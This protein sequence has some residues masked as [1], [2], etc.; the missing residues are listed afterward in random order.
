MFVAPQAQNAASAEFLNRRITETPLV[1]F[2]TSLACPPERKALCTQD[3]G[4][5]RETP[6]CRVNL[7]ANE[8]RQHLTKPFASINGRYLS[9]QYPAGSRS[10]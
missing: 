10:S 7:H 3:S 5:V 4:G 1:L 9:S 8:P 6:H 2:I